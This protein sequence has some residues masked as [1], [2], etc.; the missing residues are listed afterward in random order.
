MRNSLIKEPCEWE[1]SVV[2]RVVQ[3]VL[4]WFADVGRMRE[5]ERERECVKN[6]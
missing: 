5:R 3:N 2:K 6:G 4:K 1:M